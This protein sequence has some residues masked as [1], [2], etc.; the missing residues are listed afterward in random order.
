MVGADETLK[1]FIAR[2]PKV[3]PYKREPQGE[4]ITFK[5]D[6]SG[7]YTISELQSGE[8]SFLRFY[9]RKEITKPMQVS[10]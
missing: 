4:A 1:D 5:S 7:F 6:G 2:K 10:K 8:R 3:L 9:K